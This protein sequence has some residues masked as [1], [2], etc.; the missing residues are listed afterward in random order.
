MNSN[1]NT[2]ANVDN[3]VRKR[4]AIVD[5]CAKVCQLWIRLSRHWLLKKLWHHVLQWTTIVPLLLLRLLLL[6]LPRSKLDAWQILLFP[7]IHINVGI[8]GMLLMTAI[9]RN[10]KNPISSLQNS[11]T[12]RSKLQQQPWSD[13]SCQ[14]SNNINNN[15]IAHTGPS[16]NNKPSA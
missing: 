8:N 4:N 2:G 16:D 12:T 6:R 13:C 3:S 1:R 5:N 9:S 10:M 11:W 15:A 14:T 7:T